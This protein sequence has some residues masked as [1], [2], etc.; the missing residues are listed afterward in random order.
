MSRPDVDRLDLR[1]LLPL[2]GDGVHWTLERDA[3][4]NVNLVHLDAG[5]EV[6]AHVNDAVDVLVVG[7]DGTG[8][9]D[10]G[11]GRHDVAPGVV[12]HVPKGTRRTI[13][14]GALGFSYLTVHRRR[15][16]PAISPRPQ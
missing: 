4:L 3:D 13:R 9:V 7:L 16:G 12:V 2:S 14:A 6:G 5:H 1:A 10:V 11:G 8:E 15:A